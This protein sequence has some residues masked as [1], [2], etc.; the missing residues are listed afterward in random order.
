MADLMPQEAHYQAGKG[1]KRERL[2]QGGPGSNSREWGQ[3][4]KL[5]GWIWDLYW[6]H[7]E[8]LCYIDFFVLIPELMVQ[9]I[10]GGL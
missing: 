9:L 8:Q 6:I 7:C 4:K 1:R 3:M 5:R 2:S 10:L